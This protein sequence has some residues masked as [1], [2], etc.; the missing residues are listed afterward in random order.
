MAE[1]F[2][3]ALTVALLAPALSMA[4]AV[5]LAPTLGVAMAFLSLESLSAR[6]SDNCGGNSSLK[7][8]FGEVIV[9]FTRINSSR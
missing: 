8:S 1:T 5:A 3:V 6:D 2:A 7:H 4:V 9:L